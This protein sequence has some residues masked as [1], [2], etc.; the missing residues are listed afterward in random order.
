MIIKYRNKNYSSED[1]PI[2]VYFKTD[3]NRKEFLSI[4]AH[5]KLGTYYRITCTHAI[6]A[7]NTII[8]DKKAY[9]YFRIDEK[10]EKRLLQRS[11]WENDEPDNNAMMCAPS[12]I[13]ET[14]LLSW[15][16]KNI[17]RLD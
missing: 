6:L 11:L 5:Y 7:G 8:K 16:E 9:I 15:V 10:E 3:F 13:K 1:L 14:N 4:L 12:D 17:D 2:F